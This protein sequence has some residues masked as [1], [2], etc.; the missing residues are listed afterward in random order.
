MPEPYWPKK[1]GSYT[2]ADAANVSRYAKLRCRFCKTERYYLVEELKVAFGN[3]EC[4]DVPYRNNWR[5]TS[6]GNRNMIDLTIVNPSAADLQKI[7][8]RRID[9][10][11]YIRRVIWR[12]E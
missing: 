4:D 1:K 11:L 12:D 5:C 8:L 10:I 6:C 7:K 9:R 2:L 3:V